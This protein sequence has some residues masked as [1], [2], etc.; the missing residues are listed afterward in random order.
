MPFP[1]AWVP[2]LLLLACR[3]ASPQGDFGENIQIQRIDPFGNRSLSVT[4]NF[5]LAQD[6][7]RSAAEVC[8]QLFYDQD[9]LELNR[10]MAPAI[11]T[12]RDAKIAIIRQRLAGRGVEFADDLDLLVNQYLYD[13][14]ADTADAGDT[15]STYSRALGGSVAGGGGSRVCSIGAPSLSS[16]TSLM[17]SSELRELWIFLPE[18]DRA[19]SQELIAYTSELSVQVGR[20]AVFLFGPPQASLQRTTCDA[21]HILDARELQ[22]VHSLVG[23]VQRAGAP[24]RI[25]WARTLNMHA[26]TQAYPEV[27]FQGRHF[28]ARNATGDRDQHSV[29][30]LNQRRQTFPC[31]QPQSQSQPQSQPQSQSRCL[32]SWQLSSVWTFHSKMTP[33]RNRDGFTSRTFFKTEYWYHTLP[34]PPPYLPY[35]SPMSPL[36]V[37]LS[38]SISLYLSPDSLYYSLSLP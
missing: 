22:D 15:H 38:P 14:H 19:V 9:L 33:V 10:C 27:F 35:M 18:A 29:R 32:I 23:A 34:P 13:T 8:T 28:I 30:R 17:H 37:P 16:L 6:V 11:Q 31:A 5:T 21:L 26:I 1:L 12:L 2:L 36:H 24:M 20:A 4:Q 7:E 3:R 25:L